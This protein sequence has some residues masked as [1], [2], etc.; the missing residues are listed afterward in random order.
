MSVYKKEDGGLRTEVIYRLFLT[1]WD[2]F[3]CSC[4][5]FFHLKTN[6]NKTK[7]NQQHDVKITMIGESGSRIPNIMLLAYL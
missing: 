6:K 3:L 2:A 7:L 1:V 5:L 4:L